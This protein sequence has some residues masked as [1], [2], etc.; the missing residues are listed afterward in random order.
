MQSYA[1]TNAIS[2]HHRQSGSFQQSIVQAIESEYQMAL[3]A[4]GGGANEFSPAVPNDSIGWR[5]YAVVGD[6]PE[7]ICYR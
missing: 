6:L 5:A 2:W 4:L 7:V 1:D 3:L